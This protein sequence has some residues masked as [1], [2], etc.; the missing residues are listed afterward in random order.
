VA[1]LGLSIGGR[2]SGLLGFSAY[3]T[4]SVATG[5]DVVALSAAVLVCALAPFADRRGI[6]R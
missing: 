5:V 4:L 3:P 6:V 2:V 1:L